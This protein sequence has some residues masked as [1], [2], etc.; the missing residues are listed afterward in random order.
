ML[1][2]L[3]VDAL[4]ADLAALGSLLSSTSP[5]DDPIGFRQFSTRKARIEQQ[6]AEVIGAPARAASIGLFFGGRPVRGSHGIVADFGA[7]AIESFQGV[8]ATRRAS[9]L[10]PVA[11][12]GQ[13]RQ[14]ANSQ[15][16][17][18]DVVRGSF[19][20]VLEEAGGGSDESS[21]LQEV[22]TEVADLLY[23]A[24]D[25]SQAVFEEV[26]DA[27]DSRM[28]RS[29]QSFF[30]LLDDNDAT[31]RL[32]EDG[33]DVL[34]DKDDVRRARER[35]DSISL[36]EN[37]KVFRGI[38]YAIPHSKKFEILQ[39]GGTIIKGT[40]SPEGLAS[41]QADGQDFGAGVLGTWCNVEIAIKEV[42]L[43]GQ[44][45]RFS[46]RLTKVLSGGAKAPEEAE[47]LT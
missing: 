14:R 24:S 8:V 28:L 41:L 15:M 29:M 27:V 21:D 20:F 45:P 35:V 3:E 38:L 34:L 7:R 46:Y 32:V 11:S 16:L 12:H 43:R 17:I 2:Q 19:G 25:Q 40:I 30:K 39:Q 22:L 23:R 36:Q 18:T 33:F 47:T 4:K 10:G 44:A 37:T 6:L 5:E 1:K 9:R 31:M 13:V 42:R 26:A